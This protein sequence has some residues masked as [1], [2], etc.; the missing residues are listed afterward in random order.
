MRNPFEKTLEDMVYFYAYGLQ[1]MVAVRRP[2]NISLI[3]VRMYS[4]LVL[5]PSF[6]PKK[7]E[8]SI[9]VFYIT[10]FKDF[11]VPANPHEKP[12]SEANYNQKALNYN[13]RA[14]KAGLTITFWHYNITFWHYNITL[15]KQV[16]LCGIVEHDR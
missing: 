2:F 9:V 10:T 16:I 13:Q 8:L 4:F 15:A 11:S 1:C 6:L 14:L 5:F 12:F 7:R 3:T